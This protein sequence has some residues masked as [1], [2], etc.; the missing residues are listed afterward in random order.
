MEK[1]QK[2]TWKEIKKLKKKIDNL[3]HMDRK[4]P[5]FKI[6]L[7]DIEKELESMKYEMLINNQNY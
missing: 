6:F 3:D 2:P 1:E 7:K 5:Q 4:D